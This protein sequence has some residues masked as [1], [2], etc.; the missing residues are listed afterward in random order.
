MT[1]QRSAGPTR[2]A[3]GDP[4]SSSATSAD[5]VMEHVQDQLT[6]ERG[7][8]S[9][10]EARAIGVITSAGALVTLLFALAALVTKPQ[11]YELPG[12]ARLVLGITL[13]AFIASA[14]LAIIAARPETYQ[15]V[16]V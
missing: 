5:A 2:N 7:T 4:D 16:S 15:E 1:S 9:A 10:L 3:V 8:K 11:A 14:V 12:A 6:E 13:I